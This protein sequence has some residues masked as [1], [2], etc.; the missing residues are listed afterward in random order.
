MATLPV[1]VAGGAVTGAQNKGLPVLGGQSGRN[2]AIA[3]I[4]VAGNLPGAPN[5]GSIATPITSPIVGAAT[6]GAPPNRTGNMVNTPKPTAVTAAPTATTAAAAPTATSGNNGNPLSGYSPQQDQQLQ[7]QLNDIYGKGEGGLLYSLLQNLGGN[8]SSYMQAYHQAMGHTQAEGLSTIDTGL[9]NAG[10][11]ADS[12]TA[13]I[14]KGD[15]LS[16]LSAQEGLQEQQLLQ[17]QQQE[18]IGLVQGLQQSAQAE[19]STSWLNTLGQVAGIA[20]TF[21]GD[22]TGLSGVGSALS[23]LIPG[24]GG[25]Q[26]NITNGG[27]QVLPN[28]YSGGAPSTP[29]N[30]PGSYSGSVPIF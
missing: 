10:I 15:Y 28:V 9:G 13:A 6:T 21:V 26:G 12:S 2:Q 18:S 1:G 14:E 23:K 5:N 11:S 25:N 22:A 24:G 27:A 19:N 17:T 4:P 8:D 16:S 7:K 3:T 20:G 30:I 29:A